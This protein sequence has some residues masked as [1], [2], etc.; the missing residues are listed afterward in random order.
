MSTPPATTSEL[1]VEAPATDAA[2]VPG[3]GGYLYV[4]AL[5]LAWAFAIYVFSA[6]PMYWLVFEAYAFGTY[7]LVQRLYRP[8]VWLAEHSTWFCDFL[9]WWIG[10]W[11]L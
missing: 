2:A 11:V 5:Q 4:S 6:G 1:P 3:W 9:D 8:L 7:P 10:L